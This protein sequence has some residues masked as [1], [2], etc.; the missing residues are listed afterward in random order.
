MAFKAKSPSEQRIAAL[1]EEL[2][3]TQEQLAAFTSAVLPALDESNQGGGMA[4]MRAATRRQQM[5]K[6]QNT[7]LRRRAALLERELVVRISCQPQS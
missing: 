5:L 6:L 7:Q 3:Y 2:A 1:E 4:A